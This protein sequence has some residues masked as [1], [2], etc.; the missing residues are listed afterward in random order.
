MED[1]D[2][3]FCN[4]I[5]VDN[6]IFGFDEDRLNVLLIKRGIDPF[7][8]KWA[9]PGALVKPEEHIDTAVA[10]V[11][12]QLTGLEDVYLNQV[13]TFGAPDRHPDGRVITI[14]Y[15]SLINIRNYSV[16][17]TSFANQS[18]WH[19]IEKVQELAFD[20]NMILDVCLNNLRKELRNKP[21]G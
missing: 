6:V 20:H 21:I 3:Y 15:Y 4:G 5:S 19:P 7:K 16:T 14:A 1:I 9:L 12:K 8:G 13:G 11:L 2:R 10:R 18:Q 17:P